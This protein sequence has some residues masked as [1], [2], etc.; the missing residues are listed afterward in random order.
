MWDC[1]P[2]II[3]A[4]LASDP[5]TPFLNEVTIFLRRLEIWNFL[6]L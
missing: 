4:R 1:H 2:H 3:D 5:A 6:T